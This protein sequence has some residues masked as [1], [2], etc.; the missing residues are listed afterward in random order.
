MYIETVPNRNSTP[1]ILLRQGTRQGNK[2]I[3]RTLANLTHWPKHKVE[4]FRRLLQDEPLAPPNTLFSIE[5]SLPHGAVEAVL[6]TMRR[7]G[8]DTLIA[9]KASTKRSLVMAMVAEQLL[10]HSSKLGSTRLWHTTTLAEQLGVHEANEDDLYQ[11]M[12][13][14]LAQQSRIETKLAKR[15]LSPGDHVLY[16]VSSSYYEGHTCS[17]ACFG[18]NRDQKRGKTSI[19]YGVMTDAEGR[20]IA[21]EVYPGNTADPTTVPK[22]VDKLRKRFGLQHVVLVGDRGTLTQTQITTLKTYPGLG[23]ISALRFEAIRKLADANSFPAALFEPPYLAQMTSESF[24]DERLMACFNTQ[25]AAERKRKRQELL[26]CTET[27]LDKIAKEVTRRTKTPLKPA[28]IGQKVGSVLHRY[29]MGKHFRVSIDEAGFRYERRTDSIERESDLDGI[30]VIRTSEPE[31]RVSAADAVRGYKALAQVERVFRTLKGLDIRVRP[32]R[33]RIDRRVRA[34]I[35][36]C[37]LAYYVEWHMRRA[38]APVLFDDEDLAENRPHRDP[39][40]PARPS[41]SA[42]Q[43]KW[44][45]VT[46]E[47]L[48]IQSFE[49]LLAALATRCQNRCRLLC[50]PEAPPFYL[51]TDLSALQQRAFE[52]LGLVFPVTGTSDPIESE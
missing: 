19:V 3:K 17:L 20:P 52:L 29:K 43:K 14:L 34:H 37:L 30:Y 13:W 28:Q 23:W 35:F 9:A 51:M 4:T 33:H 5:Q 45:R 44:H 50:D 1:T 6:G 15:H 8:L 47:G 2:V 31:A 24:P 27:D 11:A 25:L 48:P 42:Q 36:L 40:A 12:D 18:Y 22:Q 10:H 26:A 7:I 38:L 39:V 32:I 41:T 21:L 46:P 16:D 49:T